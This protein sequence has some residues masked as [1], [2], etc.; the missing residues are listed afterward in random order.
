MTSCFNKD[1]TDFRFIITWAN[2]FN[3]KWKALKDF[4]CIIK[5]LKVY[6]YISEDRKIGYIKYLKNAIN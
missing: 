1:Y 5:P 4:N 3:F 2:I 6:S